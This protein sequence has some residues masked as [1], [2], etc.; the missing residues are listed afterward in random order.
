MISTALFI[1]TLF[2]LAI[3]LTNALFWPKPRRAQRAYAGEVSVL[4]PARNEESNLPAC[5][6]TVL[7][8]GQTVREVLVYNDHSTDG[9]ERILREFA[10]RDE[11]VRSV[12][13][14]PLAEGW[15]GKNFACAQLAGAATGN[16]LLFIDADARLTEGAVARMAEEMHQRSLTFLSCWP[17]LELV[18]FWERALMPMLNFVVFATFPSPLSLLLGSP[19]LGLA[20]GACLM[21]ERA[22]YEEVG[23]HAAVRDQIF[24]DTRLAQLWR[25]RGRRGLCLDG[26]D[27]VRVRMYSSFAEIWQGFQKNFFPAFKYELSFWFFWAFHAVVFLLPIVLSVVWPSVQIGLAALAIFMIRLALAWRFRQPL[28]AVLLHP[29]AEAILLALGLSSWWRCKSGRGVAWKGREYHKTAK[30]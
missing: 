6:E 19:S 18:S 23:G 15:C 12:E 13:V 24:E 30:V 14:L 29:L 1:V 4:I 3:A 21:F 27:V 5:L 17:G 11:R 9:T 10:A 2:L 8:Q 22:T 16:Y 26:Q 20:H 28:W 25:E 7:R